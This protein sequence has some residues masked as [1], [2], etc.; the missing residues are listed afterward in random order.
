MRE[1]L[2][3]KYLAV[4]SSLSYCRDNRLEV[5]GHEGLFRLPSYAE[6]CVEEVGN[7]ILRERIDTTRIVQISGFQS[8]VPSPS[9]G[10]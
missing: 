9:Y 3:K 1:R 8:K 2:E 5:R 6:S 4:R 10:I 7:L